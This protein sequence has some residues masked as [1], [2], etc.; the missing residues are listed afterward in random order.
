[1]FVWQGMK[2]DGANFVQTCQ[3]CIQAKLDRASYSGKLQPLLVP[4]EARE[5]VSMDFID[6]LPL[7]A[8]ASCILVV[9]DKFTRFAHFILVSHPYTAYPVAVAFYRLH[10]LLASIIS[11]RD[12]VFT[13]KF[14]QSLFKLAGTTLKLSSSYHPQTDGPTK[15]VNQCLETFLRCFVHACPKKWKD[16]LPAV[17]FWYNTSFHSSL[18]RSPFEAQPQ[19][20]LRGSWKSG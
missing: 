5:T 6:G 13:S 20:L 8:N 16:W 11:D 12:P 1:M 9:V 4:T 2:K 3:V 18:G 10:G 19:S 14:W 17:E 7:A 15:R